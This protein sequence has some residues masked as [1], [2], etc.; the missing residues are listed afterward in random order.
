MR[1]ASPR[2]ARAVALG[3]GCLLLACGDDD[4]NPVPTERNRGVVQSLVR[5]VSIDGAEARSGDIPDASATARLLPPETFRLAPDDAVLL[6]LD[7]D[8]PDAR[9]NPV[10]AVLMQFEG[11]D[12]HDRAPAEASVSGP[13]DLNF[14]LAVSD[15]V[16]ADL[17]NQLFTVRLIAAL[18]LE[19]G[20]VGVH[21]AIELELDCRDRGDPER[22]EGSG[23]TPD[24]RDASTGRDGG[25][26]P[27]PLL[28]AGLG[29]YPCMGGGSVPFTQVCDETADCADGSD[30]AFCNPQPGAVYCLDGMDMVTMT[31]LCD[32]TPDCSD[33][34]DETQYCIPCTDGSGMFS[35]FQVC[36]GAEDCADRMDEMICEFMC[37][38]GQIIDSRTVC[39]GTSDCSDDSDE[40]FCSPEFPCSDGT[41]TIPADQLC[42]GTEDCSDGSDETSCM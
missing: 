29:E 12:S 10:A 11:A 7:V 37:M 40:N 30:E 16:C 18:E 1:I 36:D 9:E 2:S 39:D 19:Q 26:E 27:P 6:P 17:C 31:Q 8:N 28:D 34:S 14:E 22:C 35:S 5:G 3:L 25:V 38:N 23:E 4:A 42:D 41:M 21:S 13:A 20:E 33:G 15:D 32:G 24:D